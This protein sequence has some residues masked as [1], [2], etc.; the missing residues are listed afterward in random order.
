LLNKFRDKHKERTAKLAMVATKTDIRDVRPFGPRPLDWI[1]YRNLKIE[2]LEALEAKPKAELVYYAYRRGSSDLDDVGFLKTH[3]E[4]LKVADSGL[5]D[6]MLSARL[7]LLDHPG[8]TLHI[9]LAAN[10]PTVCYWDPDTWHLSDQAV[11]YFELLEK[12]GIIF[13]SPQKAAQHVNKIW[14]DVNAWWQGSDVQNA[15]V[16]WS[17][18]FA[19]TDRF[20]WWA[21]IKALTKLQLSGQPV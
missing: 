12:S 20:W 2:F 13:D 3:F 1:A 5:N 17:Q 4:D 16:A 10:V 8:T 11:P 9:A 7:L 21:W 15:R 14:H 18:N 19:R 6:D